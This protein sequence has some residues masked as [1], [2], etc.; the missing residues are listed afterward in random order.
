MANDKDNNENKFFHKQA[1]A[2]KY[3]SRGE[4]EEIKSQVQGL[5]EALNKCAVAA[6]QQSNNTTTSLS[7]I[8]K[9]VN[10]NIAGLKELKGVLKR[11]KMLSKVMAVLEA[12]LLVCVTALAIAALSGCSNRMKTVFTG[13][14]PINVVD[15]KSGVECKRLYS[16]VDSSLLSDVYGEPCQV[17]LDYTN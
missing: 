3:P 7:N 14:S 2:G 1:I 10:E 16:V 15:R 5:K 12:L 6:D 4:M 13:K 8:A 17:K 11:V 9:V